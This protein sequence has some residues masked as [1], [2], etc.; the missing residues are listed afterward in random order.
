M[1]VPST[2]QKSFPNNVCPFAVITNLCYNMLTWLGKNKY[3]ATLI[4]DNEKE[5]RIYNRG[6]AKS[7]AVKKGGGYVKSI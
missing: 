3:N 7:K 5:F 6:R 1:I 2:K 4:F